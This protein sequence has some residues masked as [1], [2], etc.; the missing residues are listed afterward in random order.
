MQFE[1]M[2]AALHNS[3]S[4]EASI[5]LAVCLME[6]LVEDIEDESG[7]ELSAC[8][9]GGDGLPPKLLW[10]FRTAKSL[11]AD[12]RESFGRSRERLEKAAQ[13][14]EEKE[15]ELEKCVA[16]S[17]D[18][19]Q[20]EEKKRSVES[21]LVKA[22]DQRLR[23]Q[24][25]LKQ[26][27]EKEK[28]LKQ[29]QSFDRSAEEKKIEALDREIERLN[30]E[31]GAFQAAELMPRKK[32][33][34]AVNAKYSELQEKLTRLN[35]DITQAENAQNELIKSIALRKDSLERQMEILA[36]KQQEQGYVEQQIQAAR[37]KAETAEQ[38]IQAA[39]KSLGELQTQTVNLQS[40][41][42]PQFRE[43]VET[44]QKRKNEWEEA[45]KKKKQEFAQIQKSVA[46]L[47]GQCQEKEKDLVIYRANY[48]AL[49]ADFR[50]KTAELSE[51][52]K[53]LEELTGQTD[54]GK[55]ETYLRQ[56]KDKIA[57]LEKLKSD[58]LAAE[59]DNSRLSREIEQKQAELSSL[60]AVLAQKEAT[61]KQTAARLKELKLLATPEVQQNA[62]LMRERLGLLEDCREHLQETLMLI[63][64]NV[65][66]PS[67]SEDDA[68]VVNAQD[69]LQR[70][71]GFADAFCTEL[72][73]CAELCEKSLQLQKL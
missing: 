6:S 4:E 13:D 48:D 12:N 58:T 73:S 59:E 5:Y 41:E 53:L 44:E 27:T 2:K 11:F 67:L 36:Q 10:L 35:D 21:A 1:R 64:Q 16:D 20:L 47:K 63:R 52:E 15:R 32:R 33:L 50:S 68:L 3:A 19:L 42:L 8:P 9:V 14:L 61:E 57:R 18:L 72:E 34:E 29:L 70:M 38:Q 37:K 55:H 43:L 51:L 60:R 23:A 24:E 54:T 26:I 7:Q 22:G 46:E 30:R 69:T 17:R 71:R 45:I 25:L 40:V 39:R 56:K 65:D 62:K 28:E 31:N 49:T 66:A